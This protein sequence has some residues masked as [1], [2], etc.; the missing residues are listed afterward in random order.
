MRVLITGCSGAGK[1]T[2]LAELARRGHATVTEPGRRVIDAE[3]AGGGDGFPWQNPLRFARSCLVLAE[4][5][6][7]QAGP[8][9][10]FFDRGTLD[11][12]LAL[13]R[14]GGHGA[15]QAMLAL[16]PYDLVVLAPPWRDLFDAGADPDRRHD[17]AAAT[18][19][20]RD[21]SGAL[22]AAGETPLVLPRTSVG[23]RADWLET[24]LRT[25]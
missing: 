20:Y 21:I 3:R 15:G 22:D 2:L 17:F 5:D 23:A 12:V 9:L 4:Q 1:S 16:H 7:R 8:G 11:S 10:T 19:E 6:L 25:G 18:T 13:Q 24:R 14:A